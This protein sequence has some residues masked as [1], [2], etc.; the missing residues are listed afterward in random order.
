MSASS[1]R[2]DM[3]PKGGYSSIQWQRIPLKKPWSGFKAFSAYFLI[4]A[5]AYCGYHESLR[6]RRRNRRENEELTVAIEPLLVAERDRMYLNQ[7]RKNRE[8]EAD[9]MKNVPGWKVGTYY[10]Q[11]LYTTVGDNI[12]DPYSFEY[13]AHAHPNDEYWMQTYDFWM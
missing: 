6:L 8:E 2:Q 12:I 4:S 5:A 10:G 7:L 3:P 13:Y 1:A 11:P 9:L